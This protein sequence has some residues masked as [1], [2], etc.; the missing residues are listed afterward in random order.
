MLAG[1]GLKSWPCLRS[2]WYPDLPVWC[3]LGNGSFLFEF[4]YSPNPHM[5]LPLDQV[6]QLQHSTFSCV[7]STTAAVSSWEEGHLGPDPKLL[8]ASPG[9]HSLTH[10]SNPPRSNVPPRA[11]F[12]CL[13]LCHLRC[14][15]FPGHLC[16]AGE[17]QPFGTALEGHAR[18]IFYRT[19]SNI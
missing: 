1:G 10:S 5:P 3:V 2:W 13:M 6:G 9:H 15:R 17:L 19:S 8:K 18:E 12:G 4:S 16:R 14:L 11:R 7:P